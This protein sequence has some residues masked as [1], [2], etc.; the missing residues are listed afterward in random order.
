MRIFYIYLPT[1][2]WLSA[3]YSQKANLTR[4]GVITARIFD[5]KD[6][7]LKVSLLKEVP[8][9]ALR[10]IKE[11]DILF[12]GS[13]CMEFVETIKHTLWVNVPND[14]SRDSVKYDTAYWLIDN[15]KAT[16]FQFRGPSDT[17]TIISR[18]ILKDKPTGIG[19]APTRII[20]NPKIG[21][22][23]RIQL[24][25][26]TIAGRLHRRLLL[27]AVH[28]EAQSI[29]LIK[30]YFDPA[31]ESVP[32]FYAK[33]DAEIQGEERG[34]LRL[35]E[36]EA[37]SGANRPVFKSAALFEIKEKPPGDKWESIFKAWITRIGKE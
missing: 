32:D 14:S 35:I 21:Q 25:D 11:T 15:S 23:S 36:M 18:C 20:D 24:P 34:F 3:C 12:Y 19:A 28:K 5:Y 16:C 10:K 33:Q 8:E 4:E 31:L 2:F 17:A 27:K 13:Y 1:F 30:Y 22:L 9:A 26:T 6:P 37:Y 29:L 7:G